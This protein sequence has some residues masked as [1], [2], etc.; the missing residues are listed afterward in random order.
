MDGGWRLWRHLDTYWEAFEKQ[1]WRRSK[2]Q[3]APLPPIFAESGSCRISLCYWDEGR[4]QSL[5]ELSETDVSD[6]RKVTLV[7]GMPTP[8]EAGELL[9]SFGVAESEVRGARE[10]PGDRLPVVYA[11]NP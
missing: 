11:R 7:W 3:N 4:D 9:A 10:H 6:G 1:G 8:C 5:F 2:A